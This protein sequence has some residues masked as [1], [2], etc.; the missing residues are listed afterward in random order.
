RADLIEMATLARERLGDVGRAIDLWREVVSRFGDDDESIGALADLYTENGSF[1]D[2][3]E[4]LSRSANVD[5]GHHADR[6]A[7]LADAQRLRLGD[8]RAAVDWY[9]RALDVDPAHE[10]ARAGLQALL[11][12]VPL[13]LAAA[14]DRGERAR[15]LEDAAVCADTRAGDQ[16]R[17]LAWLCEALPLAGASARL[18]QE[19]LRLAEATGDFAGVARA[20]GETI[21]A[22]GAPALTLAHLHELR[23]QLLETRISDLGAA[24]ASYASALALTPERLEPRR[25]LLRTLVRVGRFAD[26]AK[27]LVEAGT[28]R[29]ARDAELLPLFESLARDAGKIGPALSALE[30]AID[31]AS[32][33]DAAA[34]RD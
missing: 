22:G 13:R 18:E 7:R 1:A 32:G 20:L 4:L 15:I 33:L 16:K 29:D 24:T 27:L 26:A 28:N 3:A 17:A 5:R 21:A 25:S 11:D 6:L 2:L 14:A 30:E 8:A 9:G 23:G 31:A 12:L 34:R 19:V 10:G